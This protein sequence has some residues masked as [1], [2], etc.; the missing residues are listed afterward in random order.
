MSIGLPKLN[1]YHHTQ[2]ILAIENYGQGMGREGRRQLI[3]IKESATKE[4]L[5]RERVREVTAMARAK[6]N[7]NGN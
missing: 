3:P 7:I 4:S 6:V 5:T 2:C 1:H